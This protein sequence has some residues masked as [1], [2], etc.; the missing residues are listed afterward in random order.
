M[1][2]TAV[3]AKFSRS[4]AADSSKGLKKL[5]TEVLFTLTCASSPAAAAAAAAFFADASARRL[6]SPTLNTLVRAP[7]KKAR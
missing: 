1:S 7:W 2:R 6:Y 3:C 5:L 4:L